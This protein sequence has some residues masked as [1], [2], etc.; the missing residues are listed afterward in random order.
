MT[1]AGAVIN[2]ADVQAGD[3]VAVIGAGGVGL[4]AVRP[5]K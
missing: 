3:S 4:S 1:G 5:P 2:T